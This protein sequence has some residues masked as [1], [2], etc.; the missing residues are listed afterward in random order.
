L[1]VLQ[2]SLYVTNSVSYLCWQ[3]ASSTGPH[4]WL[5][6]QTIVNSYFVVARSSYCLSCVCL[7]FV[8]ATFPRRRCLIS[9]NLS[10]SWYSYG[11]ERWPLGSLSQNTHANRCKPIAHP[12]IVGTWYKTLRYPLGIGSWVQDSGGFGILK[13]G[14]WT[15]AITI[16]SL[17]SFPPLLCFPPLPFLPLPPSHP[18][19][20]PTLPSSSFSHPVPSLLLR[21]RPLK[22]SYRGS[23]GAP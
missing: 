9:V 12:I 23:W 11:Y 17:P 2:L 14:G 16:P 22:S 10:V 4:P 3:N 7:M 6:H 19:P 1:F 21:S 18:F 13:L 5:G 20:S 15:G 8:N